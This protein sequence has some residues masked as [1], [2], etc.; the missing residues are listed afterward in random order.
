MGIFAN[1]LAASAQILAGADFTKVTSN[2][3]VIDIETKKI[4]DRTGVNIFK[5]GLIKSAR[6]NGEKFCDERRRKSAGILYVFQTFATHF[7]RKSSARCRR[8]I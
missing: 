5:E 4:I 1:S 3:G 6:A 7:R 8:R 2:G